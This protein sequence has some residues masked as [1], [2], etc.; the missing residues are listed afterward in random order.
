MKI[1]SNLK[2]E[3]GESFSGKSR[4]IRIKMTGGISDLKALAEAIK[5]SMHDDMNNPNW[6][7]TLEKYK[8]F[9]QAGPLQKLQLGFTEKEASA[10]QHMNTAKT[11]DY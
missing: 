7:L 3:S 10:K 1:S 6:E 11:E 5:R 2:K 8:K 9:G 4:Q